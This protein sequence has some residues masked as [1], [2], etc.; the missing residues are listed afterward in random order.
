MDMLLFLGPGW[1]VIQSLQS[2]EYL[3]ATYLLVFY[4]F[5][6]IFGSE[7]RNE[8]PAKTRPFK[9]INFFDTG[10]MVPAISIVR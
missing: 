7:Y 2:Y 9:K 6:D 4:D 5:T 10:N 1:K 3:W 8:K